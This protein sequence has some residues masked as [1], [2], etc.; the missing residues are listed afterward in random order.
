MARF[1]SFVLG[2]SALTALL[3][4]ATVEA[5][6]NHLPAVVSSSVGSIEPLADIQTGG[7]GSEPAGGVTLGNRHIFPAYS[8]AYGQEL[9]ITDGTTAGTTLLKDINPGSSNS[10]YP[11]N[12]TKI[13]NLVYFQAYEATYGAELWVTDGTT[14]GTRLLK[15][16]YPG[17]NGNYPYGSNPRAFIQVG[18]LVVFVAYTATLGEEVWVTDGTSIGTALVKD[19]HA[20]PSSSNASY[21]ALLDNKVYFRATDNNDNYELWVTDGTVNG[22]TLVKDIDS[23]SG[24]SGNPLYLTV[25]GDKLIFVAN[26]RVSGEE[27]WISDGTANGTTMLKDI[28]VNSD[29]SSPSD[30]TAVGSRVFFVAVDGINGRELWSTDG[31]SQGTSLVKDIYAGSTG[32]NPQ[33]LDAVNGKLYFFADEITTGREPY[34]SDGTADGTH[35]LAE[36][37]P[38]INSSTPNCSGMCSIGGLETSFAGFGDSVVF[39]AR[40]STLGSEPFISDGTANGTRRLADINPGLSGSY[41]LPYMS[42][43]VKSHFFSFENKLLILANDGTIGAEFWVV[44][45]PVNPPQNV[46]TSATTNSMTIS[47]QA[48]VSNIANIGSYNVTVNPGGFTCTTSTLS[49]TVTGLTPNTDYTASVTA[50]SSLGTSA[51]AVAARVRTPSPQLGSLV[52]SLP[53]VTD[54]VSDPELETSEALNV[55]YSGFSPNE[56]VLLVLASNPVVIGSANADA[57]GNVVISAII[58]AGTT[59]GAH[60]LVLFAPISGFGASQAV[61]VAA[62]TTTTVAPAPT[63][64]V[65]GGTTSNAGATDSTSATTTTV[66]MQLVDPATLPATGRN[67]TPAILALFVLMAGLL[68]LRLRRP[69]RDS[70]NS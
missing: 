62:A 23:V 57:N 20:G 27:I 70:A 47:W 22:T 16:I 28:R 43:S 26:D 61:T 8:A 34:V 29:G 40:E 1:S 2:A 50:T 54:I 56:L 13:G 30:L 63:T 51:P 38:G 39:Y 9:W 67:D 41:W 69:R 49:C 64:T 31:T 35:L 24:T 68:A 33:N 10:S 4:P 18:N 11:T 45:S 32:S 12:L 58:P 66:T 19:I 7:N 55:L 60:H 21:F 25:L 15:D 44:T 3:A 52:G 5:T 65:G 42:S 14:A 53:T 17:S 36:I 46:S 59:A 48:A 37:Y 6:T